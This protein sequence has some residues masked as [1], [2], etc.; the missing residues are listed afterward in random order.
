MKLFQ[1]LLVAPA[2][3]GLFSPFSA[4][5]NELKLDQMSDYYSRDKVKSITVFSTPEELA[6]KLGE[7]GGT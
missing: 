6:K 7:N 3:L 2:I 1:K 4:T 5:A